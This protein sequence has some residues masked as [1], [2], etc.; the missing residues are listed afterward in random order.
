ML[1]VINSDGSYSGVQYSEDE[2]RFRDHHTALGQSCIS[3]ERTL[4]PDQNGDYGSPTQD[5]LDISAEYDA[6]KALEEIDRKS[7]RSIRTILSNNSTPE[8][9]QMLNAL[10]AEAVNLRVIVSQG[11]DKSNIV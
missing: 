10:E 2:Q 11:G 9:I 1:T 6:K 8:D 5:D 3:I 4:V 7:I